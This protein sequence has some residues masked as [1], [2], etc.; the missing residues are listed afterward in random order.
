M[1]ASAASVWQ[2]QAYKRISNKLQLSEESE[3][4]TSL[5]LRADRLKEI[6]KKLLKERFD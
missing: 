5:K 1:T 6:R 4:I 2:N 3:K